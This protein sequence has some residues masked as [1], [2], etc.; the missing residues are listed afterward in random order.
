M[1]PVPEGPEAT[2]GADG[3]SRAFRERARLEA[4]RYG[5]DPWV[6]VRELLQNSRD[7]GA[8]NVTLEVRDADGKEQILCS[9][10]GEG[11]TF[12][13]A[14]RYLFSLYASSKED[15]RNQAGKFGVGFWSILR[16]EPQWITVRSRPR[17]GQGFGLRL[18]GALE[19][20]TQV[21]PL[22]TV[23]TQILLERTG[24]DGRLEHRVFDA[25]WQSARYLHLRD[26]PDRPLLVTVNG[27]SANADFTLPAPSAT[28]RRGSVRGVVGLG[29]APRVE[30][31]S[32]GLRVRSAASLEDLVA[33][34]GRHTSRMR[35][36]FPELPGGVAPQ[37]LLESDKLEV[38]LSRSDARDNRALMRLVRLAQ[39]E[40]ERLIDHQLAAARPLSWP[41][42]LRAMLTTW[43]RDSLALRTAM[44]SLVGVAL[45]VLVGWWLW[46]SNTGPEPSI[47]T[48]ARH[49]ASASS[50]TSTPAP[51]AY[52]DLGTR[53]RGPKVD[54]LSPGSAEPIE[55]EYDPADLRLHFAALSFSHLANDGSPVHEA[56]AEQLQPYEL[57]R[58]TDPCVSVQLPLAGATLAT[59]IPVPTGHRVV[60]GSV[61]LDGVPVPIMV[62]GEGHPAVVLS[63][64]KSGLLRFKTSP[65]ADPTPLEQ[66]STNPALPEDLRKLALRLRKRPIRNRV[67]PLLTEVRTR[68]RYDRAP[69]VAARHAE[70]VRNGQGF[71]T[72]TLAIGAGDCDVQNGLLVALLHAAD[73]PARLAVGYV[74][75]SGTVHPWLHA[76]V[77]YRDERSRWHIADASETA[78]PALA[79]NFAEGSESEPASDD[80]SIVDDAAEDPAGNGSLSYIAAR[81]GLEGPGDSA[82][83]S[84][85]LAISAPPALS[86]SVSAPRSPWLMWAAPVVLLGLLGTWPLLRH[87]TRRA[88]KLDRGADLSKL[89]QGVLQQPSA[90]GNSS[91]LFNRP[92]VPLMRGGAIS[93]HRARQLAAAGRLYGTE[94]RPWL[95]KR[96]SR[97]G[98]AVI[99]LRL[100]EGRTV[101]DALGAIDLDRWSNWIEQSFADRLVE[102]VNQSTRS[103][104]ED[105]GIR[106]ACNLPGEI[107]V[108]D[109]RALGVRLP[110]LRAGRL[111]L[112]DANSPWV[113]QGRQREADAPEFAVFM[114]LDRVAEHLDLPSRRRAYLLSQWARQALLETFP[115]TEV[116]A[117]GGRPA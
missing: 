38:M 83:A 35:V 67:K 101:A 50:P 25:V 45:A 64:P 97:A 20:A 110:S 109:L 105:W 62:S 22:G 32:R 95:A 114:V 70:A 54:V 96:A 113:T 80:G 104:G 26:A 78:E 65:A 88:I 4:G 56:V 52:Q 76:W 79:S 11:M 3:R 23:G 87:R 112:L 2:A 99:D 6:F 61:E 13:H 8:R 103:R 74:G 37:A 16:F 34:A 42:R 68:V 75:H 55:L 49:S 82:E 47:G 72:R 1:K 28:F 40:L 107:A 18:D 60:G 106:L 66:L 33:P 84:S 90:F 14:R 100:P 31:F 19:H 53:Y 81:T 98:A 102:R 93:L 71:I 10:D 86:G 94:R 58:C 39:Q 29:P 7:A 117:V 27:R 92:L 24:G 12:E 5:P 51:R 59:R 15:N 36:R 9:D 21:A 85:E 73:V 77:E 30:L 46:G 91:A 116:P 43:F 69:L 48:Q 115:P 108:L 63:Q 57:T 89:L 111:V 41:L 17:R 44:G